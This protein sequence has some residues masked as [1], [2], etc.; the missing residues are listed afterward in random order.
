MVKFCL[1]MAMKKTILRPSHQKAISL[2]TEKTKALLKDNLVDILV[3][4]SAARG[5][6]TKSSDIDVI[7]IVKK[8]TFSTQMR[9]AAL[10][11]DLLMDTGQYISVQTMKSKDLNREAIHAL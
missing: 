3:Y 10:A 4:G 6:A 7:V 9:L 8:E 2:F 5:E 1:S 11:F